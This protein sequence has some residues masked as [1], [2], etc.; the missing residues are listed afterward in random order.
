[1]VCLKVIIGMRG[2]CY[3]RKKVHSQNIIIRPCFASNLYYKWLL[4]EGKVVYTGN[5]CFL[6][7]NCASILYVFNQRQQ[8]VERSGS[9]VELRLREPG[10]ESWLRR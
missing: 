9:G 3:E 10:F 7:Y 1:M 5:Q 6:A 2:P 4:S 8:R